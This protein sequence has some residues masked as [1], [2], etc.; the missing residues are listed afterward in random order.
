MY[1]KYFLEQFFVTQ[2]LQHQ[3]FKKS[4]RNI[5]IGYLSQVNFEL[6]SNPKKKK[7]KKNSEKNYAINAFALKLKL[8]C[9]QKNL[10]EDL[11]V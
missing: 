10:K 9:L 3:N 5:F 2:A 6:F 7:K 11:G 4:S 8:F 1:H